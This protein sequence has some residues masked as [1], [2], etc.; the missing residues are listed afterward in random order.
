MLWLE[1]KA[2]CLIYADF[3]GHVYINKFNNI[4][5]SGYFTI[6]KKREVYTFTGCVFLVLC[7][8]NGRGI[9]H[10]FR[11]EFYVSYLLLLHN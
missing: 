1:L 4:A 10:E 9:A 11:T 7:S 2:F 3:L 6:G 5:I 8:I